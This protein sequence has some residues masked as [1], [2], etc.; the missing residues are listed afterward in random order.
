MTKKNLLKIQ[1][2]TFLDEVFDEDMDF[3]INVNFRELSFKLK[4]IP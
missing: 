4:V 2:E 1:F 3:K